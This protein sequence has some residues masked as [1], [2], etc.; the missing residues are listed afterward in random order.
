[1]PLLKGSVSLTR[2]RADLPPESATSQ[3]E[4]LLDALRLRAFEPIAVQGEEERAAGFVELENH[5]ATDFSPT[6]AFQGDWLVFSWRV[7]TIRISA[8]QLREELAAW[9]QA[10]ENEHERPPSRFEKTEAKSAL[11]KELRAVTPPTTKVYD[12]AWNLSTGT[13]QLYCLSRKV[14]DEIQAAIEKS[15][16]V[17]LLPRSPQVLFDEQGLQDAHVKPTPQLCWPG[18]TSMI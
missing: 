14:V 12:V 17:T 16:D 3:A 8:A 1:M 2:F 4:R 9:S 7:D 5:T 11:R 13:I 10:F 15:F 18:F 6:A